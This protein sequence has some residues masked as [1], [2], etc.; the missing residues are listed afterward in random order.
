MR[1]IESVSLVGLGAIGAA[2]GSRL[3]NELKESFRVVANARRIDKY[4]SSGVK[5]NGDVYHFN[6]I[7]PEAKADSADLVIFAVKNTE[8]PQAIEDVK[9]HIGPDTIILSL[10]NGISSEDEI[11]SV[12]KSDHILHSVSV[13]IDA[14][15]ENNEIRFSTLGR[16]V[17]GDKSKS[18]S[19]DVLAVKEL[20]DRAGIDYTISENI[21]HTMWWKFMMNVGI[22][23]TS[24]ALKA[25]YGVFQTLPIAY[26]W[27]ESA[28]R[29][30]VELSR[31]TGANLTE[32]DVKSFWPILNNLSPEG[33]T[34]MLQDVEA[35]RKTEVE[36]FG[37]K[38]C[39]LGKR[40]DVPTPVN[41]QLYKFIRIIEEKE[42]LE[43]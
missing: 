9:H 34:S 31:K 19:D 36:Y 4:S 2:Y 12:V 1:K 38:V 21:L 7:T 16:I 40:Y 6:Y 13:E 17:F 24:A 42:K 43:I 39:E 3:H 22:N 28:M 26:E 18:S 32:E 10:L 33:K 25:P 20:F 14:V 5:V 41:D 8:L 35:G 15:R 23:Q 11:Y 37:G 30:V 27:A 29:E